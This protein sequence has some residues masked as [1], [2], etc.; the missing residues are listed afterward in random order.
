LLAFRKGNVLEKHKTNSK[1]KSRMI[2]ITVKNDRSDES[3]TFY[4]KEIVIGSHESDL[5]L[6]EEKIKPEHIKIE[7]DK[8]KFIIKNLANDP[9]VT[10]ND[11]P[12]GKRHLNNQ[13]V[14][15]IGKTMILFEGVLT[16]IAQ[17]FHEFPVK[18]IK[19]DLDPIVEKAIQ[20]MEGIAV[21]SA[22]EER[23]HT[24]SL[25]L[26]EMQDLDM[27][28]GFLEMN[29]EEMETLLEEWKEIES[30]FTE[31]KEA[32][33]P[34]ILDLE[35]NDQEPLPFKP[36]EIK[37]P[38]PVKKEIPRKIK[39]ISL[40]FILILLTLGLIAAGTLWNYK[41]E[42]EKKIKQV[43]RAIADISFAMTY[44]KI[45]HITPNQHNWT[46]PQ[47]LKSSVTSSLSPYHF[48]NLKLEGN[49]KIHENYLLR[50][51]TNRDNSRFVIIAQ[52]SPSLFHYFSIP[53]SIVVDSSLMTINRM[54]DLKALNRL[55]IDS[56]ELKSLGKDEVADTIRNSPVIAMDA[57][58][59]ELNRNGFKLPLGAENYIYNSPRYSQ[60]GE[61][62][63]NDMIDLAGASKAPSEA[64]KTKDLLASIAKLP[65]A[66]MYTTKGKEKA[67]L[68]KK[69]LDQ[70][71]PDADL[72]IAYIDYD[73]S[74]KMVSSTIVKG[75][76]EI[77]PNQELEG[78]QNELHAMISK[79]I[80]APGSYSID[81]IR[82][83]AESLIA[84]IENRNAPKNDIERAQ[85]FEELFEAIDKAPES[86]ETRG[87]VIEKL[88]AFLFEPGLTQEQFNENTLERLI[89]SL[90]KAQISDNEEYNFY[91]SEFN[92]RK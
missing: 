71:A 23:E 85:T 8:G 13:D 22:L 29:Q 46:N 9:Y 89:S 77:E 68:A 16:E 27:Q 25:E 75:E 47:F 70:L 43:S 84:R 5:V 14:I 54:N 66:V 57:L 82:N 7:E 40:G 73:S 41:T 3:Y 76:I 26:E 59:D 1:L 2:K 51:Y 42:S 6:Q 55:L 30:E 31:K 34:V 20:K 79:E 52:P 67:R 12:F 44:A 24:M 17:T 65:S 50:I 81:Q 19:E 48:S 92:L 38:K 91:I 33:A 45:H 83:K 86:R 39:L 72:H 4:K 78:L 15:Q 53:D 63:M 32:P 21:E 87:K 28:E 62:L 60:V 80:E 49:G 18:D 56:D 37:I 88:N 64:R 61:K 10:L 58:A 11:L 35:E 74:S 36:R 69:A 90:K